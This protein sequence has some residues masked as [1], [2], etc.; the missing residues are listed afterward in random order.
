MEF[1]V[2]KRYI[3][4]YFHVLQIFLPHL[5]FAREKVYA[6][7]M[8]EKTWL[9]I[10][11]QKNFNEKLQHFHLLCTNITMIVGFNSLPSSLSKVE[12]V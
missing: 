12:Q 11:I 10:P 2:L 5:H 6:F 3:T 8:E 7:Q 9:M 1:D 4:K